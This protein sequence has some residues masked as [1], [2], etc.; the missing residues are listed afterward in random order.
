MSIIKQ[1]FGID[2]SK[3]S[4]EI[5]FGTITDRQE[6]RFLAAA[7][8]PNARRGYLRLLAWAKKQL[9]SNEAPVWFVMEATGVYYEQLA[10]FLAERQQQI[11]V[12]LPNKIKNFAK[13]LDNKSKTDGL[14]A[15]S[16]C[17]F[18]LER[19][20]NAWQPPSPQMRSLKAL[21]REYQTVQ[22]MATQV[23]NQL[24]AKG[25]SYEPSQETLTRLRAQLRL[26]EKQ[27]KS[28]GQQIRSLVESD[29]D[30]N[31]RISNITKAKGIGFMTVVSTVAET[32]GFALITSTK[33]ISS[34]AGLDVVIKQSGKRQG[35]P[36]IS[37]KGNKHLRSAVFMPAL[38]AC[39]CNP[40]L[41][42]FYLRL[43]R[44][45]ANKMVAVLAVARKI[46]C[47]IYTLWKKNV[48]YD[49]NY[50]NPLAKNIQLIPTS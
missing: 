40:P 36:A 18:G 21:T 30:L 29:D 15:H 23:K 42:A 1:V 19:P 48:P 16:I 14:D 12:L 31:N 17:Q 9:V 6:E 26:F 38:A 27:L 5:R 7:S 13:S 43:V 50:Q 8:F 28:I 45:K 2:V 41:R 11:V 20:L 44:T 46:L 22:H 10:Y 35:K 47:L 4:F 33:Q 37:K 49:P 39:R 34:Y 32:N 24:H 3:D 25:H